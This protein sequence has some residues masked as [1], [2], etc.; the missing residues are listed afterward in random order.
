M[1]CDIVIRSW[2]NDFEWL[3]Y[4]LRSIQRFA[5]GFRNVIVVTPNGQIPPTGAV[6]TVF[7]VHE[8]GDGYL[9]QQVTK[10]HADAFSDADYLAYLDSDTIWTRP[11][12]PDDLIVN[13][14][15]RWL[16]TPYVSI[17]RGN[18][19]T[20]KEP[21]DKVMKRPVENE[22][23]RRHGMVIPRWALEGF[24]NWMWRSHG[25]S[26]ENYILT[27]PNRSFSEFNAIGAY[28][29][30]HHFDRVLWQNTD[31]DLGTPFVWQGYSWG[32]CTDEIRSKLELA[33]A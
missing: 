21:T 22:F 9:E 29:W 4:S 30:F 16:Y 27:Q 18:G 32:G 33:I 24:R 17:G 31:D 10:L 25:M 3:K 26:L 15:V 13:G 8:R 2:V 6:E 1:N 28:M 7:H 5:T 19:Q 11:V 12:C 23:M 14:K 20:W